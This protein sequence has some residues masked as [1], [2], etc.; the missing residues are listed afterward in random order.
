M[1][2]PV[3]HLRWELADHVAT[4]TIARPEKRNCL[5][6]AMYRGLARWLH[7]LDGIPEARVVVLRGEG[8]TFCAGS[9][10]N[11]FLNK[12]IVDR[13]RHFGYV[14]DLL[15][16]PSRISKPVIA[17]PRG[18]ALG[19]GTALTAAADFALAEENAIFGIPE[20]GLGIWP[21]TIMP[22]VVR[23]VGPRRAYELFVTGRRFLAP[24]AV[25]MG[26]VT[27]A[28][29][30]DR[31]EEELWAFAQHIVGLSPLVVQMGKR[32]FYEM[33]DLEHNKAIRLMSK[34]MAISSASE[35]AREG[36]TAFL[37]KRKPDWQGR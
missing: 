8:P 16:A 14:A 30:A 28:V 23:A 19:G 31:F 32:A 2:E 34:V 35:D 13:E 21:C 26:L 4:L 11:Y 37:A 10:I 36:I 17:A 29:P 3:E 18:Y 1:L 25:A 12:S 6:D 15:Q 20:V 9:D 7:A 27:R 24:E 33:A 5:T 22:V